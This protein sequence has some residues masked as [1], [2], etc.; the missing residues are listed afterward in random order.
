[1]DDSRQPSAAALRILSLLEG[2]RPTYIA[3]L[4]GRFVRIELQSSAVMALAGSTSG[5]VHLLLEPK[6]HVVQAAAQQLYENGFYN[7]TD[8]GLEIQVTALDI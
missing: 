2:A 8:D 6:R 5:D 7:E 3:D 1:M 4:N